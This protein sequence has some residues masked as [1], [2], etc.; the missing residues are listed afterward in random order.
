[1]PNESLTDIYGW[2]NERMF[3]SSCVW[4]VCKIL[5]KSGSSAPEVLS[6]GPYNHT[7]DWWSLGI[8]LFA[9]ATGKVRTN[10]HIF[11][12][13]SFFSHCGGNDT[14]ACG[15]CVFSAKSFL[16]PP[17]SSVSSVPRTGSL[18]HAEEGTL[19]PL[20]DAKKLLS[21]FCSAAYR[22]ETWTPDGE[23]YSP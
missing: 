2:A 22:G 17:P 3:M 11:A 10:A 21:S 13:C 18:L 1:M 6:G 9:L 14:F 23:L 5:M 20:W 4:N 15:W 7:A 12:Y 19:L 16:T 8:L